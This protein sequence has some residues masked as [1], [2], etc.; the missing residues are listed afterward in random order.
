MD[1]ELTVKQSQMFETTAHEVFGGGS[2]SGGKTFLNKVLAIAI[3]EQVPGA[4][5]AILRNTSKNLKK[6]YFMGA[7]SIPLMLRDQIKSG[8]VKINY[9]DL[10]VSW[11]TGSVIHFMHAEH[12]ETTIDNLTGLEFVLVIGDEAGL[13]DSRIINH[14]K[15]RLRIGS[16]KI[17]DEFWR[18]RLPRLQLTSN[19]SGISHTYLKQTY[20]DPATPGQEFTDENGTRKLFIP[21]GARENPH[22]DYEAYERQLLAM[23]DA[24]KYKQLALGDWDAGEGSYFGDAFKRAKNV[25]PDF[26]PPKDWTYLRGYDA[27]YASPFGYVIVARVRGQNSVTAYDGRVLYFPNDSMVVYREWYGYD[28]K[29]MN[30]GIMKPQKLTHADVARMM[31]AKEEDWGLK[32]R[33]RPGRADWKIWEAELNVYDDYKKEGI[34]FVKAD[35]AKGS[36]V[37][38]ALKMRQ[39]MFA[40]HAEPI[41]QPALFFVDKCVHCIATIPTLPSHPDNPDDVATDN[42]PDH[43]YDALRYNVASKQQTIGAM[44]VKG[45]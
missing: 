25:V 41:E 10:V 35:K 39:M 11:D 12:V 23:G 37:S 3:A 15:S 21:F 42:V 4:Q 43:L 36:R 9:T 8:A 29:D 17:A 31:K 6:N 19:P 38:G 2:A 22:I 33:V 40:A 13:L 7:M 14:A 32:G 27:G 5:I 45:L 18:A 24:V 20:I 1:I 30:T 44:A 26:A 34:T 28:G 16:L